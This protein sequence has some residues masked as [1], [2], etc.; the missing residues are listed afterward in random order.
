VTELP[1]QSQA[2][3][4]IEIAKF[5]KSRQRNEHV[6]VVLSNFK[7]FNTIDVRIFHTGPDGID[8]PT[9]KGISLVVRKLPELAAALNKALK[10]A[11]TLGLLDQEQHDERA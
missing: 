11:Q 2:S 4:P 3:E 10:R 6:R 9:L 1:E 7:G 8:R 5:W